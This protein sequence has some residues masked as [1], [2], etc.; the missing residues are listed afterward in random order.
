MDGS[1][2]YA[3]CCSAFSV[4]RADFVTGR[5]RLAA[6]ITCYSAYFMP[7]FSTTLPSTYYYYMAV[8][9]LLAVLHTI[10]SHT[11]CHFPYYTSWF[12]YRLLVASWVLTLIHTVAAAIF[13]I[14][15]SIAFS[16]GSSPCYAFAL[17]S[18][19]QKASFLLPT[20]SSTYSSCSSAH[21]RFPFCLPATGFLPT[22]PLPTTYS[23]TL[24][25]VLVALLR[26]SSTLLL[27]AATTV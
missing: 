21:L 18:C 1:T 25:Y 6:L 2:Y 16:L 15:G 7:V 19:D 11:A 9:C 26:A 5:G 12:Y 13:F 23:S 24:L 10:L 4:E 22:L 17:P 3:L 14:C 20:T 8:P 27:W